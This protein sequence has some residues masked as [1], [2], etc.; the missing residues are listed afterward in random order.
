MVT[1][2]VAY[3]DQNY[4]ASPEI[5]TVSWVMLTIFFS[6]LYKLSW[7]PSYQNLM[8]DFTSLSAIIQYFP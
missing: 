3:T 2:S 4:T 5:M 8:V 6:F 1:Q 7:Q